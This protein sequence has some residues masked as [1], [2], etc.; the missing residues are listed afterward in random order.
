MH[1]GRAFSS[2]LLPPSQFWW[3]H[4]PFPEM[5][6]TVVISRTLGFLK[7]LPDKLLWLCKYKNYDFASALKLM[8]RKGTEEASGFTLL[9]RISTVQLAR[10]APQGPYFSQALWNK[11]NSIHYNCASSLLWGHPLCRANDLSVK[12][13][14]YSDLIAIAYLRMNK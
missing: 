9:F 7:S 11:I 5:T 12:A 13:L 1:S 2:Y 4:L 10:L 8:S 14:Y 3:F 6:R